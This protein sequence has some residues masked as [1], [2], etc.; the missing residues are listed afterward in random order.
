MSKVRQPVVPPARPRV[1]IYI[2]VSDQE[3]VET[4]SSLDAQLEKCKAYAA[5]HEM[6]VVEVLREEGYSAKSLQRP[7]MRQLLALAQAQEVDGVVIY[8]LDR[9]TRSLKDLLELVEKFSQ[10]NVA[11]H[12][13]SEKIDTTQATGSFMVSLLGALAELERRQIGER[14][15]FV[16]DSKR[17]REAF[18]GGFVPAGCRVVKD[19]NDRF[20]R[21]DDDWAPIVEQAWG[22]VLRGSTQGAVAR[23]LNEKHVPIYRKGALVPR[24]WHKKH[25]SDLL[26]NENCIGPLVTRED[27]DAAQAEL[28]TRDNPNRRTAEKKRL[29]GSDRANRVYPL[30]GLMRCPACETGRLLG[31]LGGKGRSYYRCGNEIGGNGCTMNALPAEDWERRLAGALASAIKDDAQLVGVLRAFALRQDE[32]MAPAKARAKQAQ[33]HREAMERA[34]QR[35]SDRF[36]AMDPSRKGAVQAIEIELDK[37]QAEVDIAMAEEAAAKAAIYTMEIGTAT[38]NALIGRVGVGLEGFAFAPPET[39]RAV[40]SVTLSEIRVAADLSE[41][42][43]I[44]RQPSKAMLA[45][46]DEA[47][48]ALSAGA[49]A[50]VAKP[51]T[52]AG[53]VDAAGGGGGGSSARTSG[54]R[55]YFRTNQP[56]HLFSA[57]AGSSP[58]GSWLP[59]E[60]SNLRPSD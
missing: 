22:M 32:L 49:G 1:V 43:L 60:D 28:G 54:I 27:Y 35:L 45:A 31:T 36:I 55:A 13:Y 57:G 48:P 23:Y 14:V 51:A 9:L 10:W 29:N 56:Q 41:V 42:E 24:T 3:Q 58:S 6:E 25:V 30:N 39:K 50:V 17:K 16:F 18:L 53:K 46:L 8:K 47:A 2:R 15:K 20:L 5:L 12:S 52:K 33:L 59:G 40:F 37:A 26:A 4:G 21:R 7:Q 34:R 38:T 19:G 44:L 11:I